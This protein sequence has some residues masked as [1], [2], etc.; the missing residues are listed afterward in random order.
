[1]P[2]LMP[3]DL[4]GTVVF[5]GLVRSRDAGP[6]SEPVDRVETTFEG[7]TGESH[8]GLTRASCSR[9][10]Q[11]YAKGT[12]IRNTRQASILSREEIAA[13]ASA[14]GLGALPPAWLGANL[15][16][17]GIPELTLLPPGARLI[18][19]GGVSLTVD[20]ENG[21]CH[22]PARVIEDHHPGKGGGFRTA[23]RNRRGVTAWVEREG[24]IG[25]GETARLHV[26]PQRLYPPLA[27][28]REAQEA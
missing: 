12:K 4:T 23:A 21:P 15:V 10:T 8:S 7:L 19:D 3:T 22:I 13:I 25:L 17:E 1:M 26:P 18:F 16:L 9:V 14:L 27:S 5:L 6:C 11:Q 2:I 20:M 28:H 24:M